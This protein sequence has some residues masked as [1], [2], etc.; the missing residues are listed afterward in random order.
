[1][2]F[3]SCLLRAKITRNR[4]PNRVILANSLVEII[5]NRDCMRISSY[6]KLSGMATEMMKLTELIL[7][8]ETSAKR[9]RLMFINR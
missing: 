4:D 8:R 3:R 6:G 1:M 9:G 2:L 5:S 7:G